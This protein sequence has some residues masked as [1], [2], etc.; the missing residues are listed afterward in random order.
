M[1]KR[2]GNKAAIVD[3]KDSKS[4]HKRPTASSEVLAN[5]AAGKFDS[6]TLPPLVLIARVLV[7]KAPHKATFA[8]FRIAE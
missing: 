5:T 6:H 7:P 4:F 8:P 1:R 3:P 2:G